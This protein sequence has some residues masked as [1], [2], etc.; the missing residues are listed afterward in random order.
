MET[1]E[2]VP[3]ESE[4]FDLVPADGAKKKALPQE[5]LRAFPTFSE[6]LIPSI[7]QFGKELFAPGQL[8]INTLPEITHLIKNIAGTSTPLPEWE[9]LQHERRIFQDPKEELFTNPHVKDVTPKLEV[10]LGPDG[11]PIV[12]GGSITSLIGSLGGNPQG[13]PSIYPYEAAIYNVIPRFI[14]YMRSP[15][16][17][18]GL[19]TG[20]AF[21]AA[22]KR[23]P[24][25]P[26]E[27]QITR[28][29]EAGVGGQKAIGSAFLPQTIAG[30]QEGVKHTVEEAKKE[31]YPASAGA[32]TDTLVNALFT[33]GIAKH[34][35]AGKDVGGVDKPTEPKKATPEP[36]VELVPVEKPVLSPDVTISER[37]DSLKQDM[38][39]KAI[40]KKHAERLGV[41]EK[42]LKEKAAAIKKTSGEEVPVERIKQE[43][44]QQLEAE[45]GLS[46]TP[47]QKLAT[48]ATQRLIPAIRE[49]VTPPKTALEIAQSREPVKKQKVSVG[50][51]TDISSDRPLNYPFPKEPIIPIKSVEIGEGGTEAK[52]AVEKVIA[53]P[54]MAGK[55]ENVLTTGGKSLIPV[56]TGD[57]TIIPEREFVKPPL[58]V[59]QP[60]VTGEIKTAT[61][62][63]ALPPEQGGTSLYSGLDISQLST[64]KLRELYM[65]LTPGARGDVRR[66]LQARGE[67][68]SD[69]GVRDFSNKAKIEA[70][71]PATQFNSGLPFTFK[72]LREL[73]DREIR[74]G[75][76][77][78]YSPDK[79][80]K[81]PAD[82]LRAGMK[83]SL[84]EG[85]LKALEEEGFF[86]EIPATGKVS[87]DEIASKVK[88][89]AAASLEKSVKVEVY[90]MEG[91]VSEA[92]K[93]YD[94]M[95]HEW[96]DT[97]KGS[98]YEK[99][100][101]GNLVVDQGHNPETQIAALKPENQSI[102]KRYYELRK[103]LKSEPADTSPRATS[104]YSHVS[105]LPTD[106]PMPD[107]T[108]TKSGKNVQRVDVVI[109][110]SKEY[111]G[112]QPPAE[113]G[114]EGVKWKADNLHENLPNTLG[115]AMIQYKT[116]AKYIGD[117][118][119]KPD[120][121]QAKIAGLMEGQ[122]RWGQEVRA[123][124]E[125]I[126]KEPEGAY[127]EQK[128]RNLAKYEH[129]LLADYNR[130]IL[131]SAIDQARKEGATHIFIS[132]A[133]SAL[134]TEHLDTQYEKASSKFSAESRAEKL[135]EQSGDNY[136]A[137]EHSYTDP[138]TGDKVEAWYVTKHE[139]GFDF[140]YDNNLPNIAEKLTGSKGEVVSI[141]EHKN[142][143]EEV[144]FHNDE[145]QRVMREEGMTREE[146]EGSLDANEVRGHRGAF[147][148]QRQNLI[149]RNKDNTGPKTDVSGRL[150]SLAP[151]AEAVARPEGGFSLHGKDQIQH[152]P[153]EG[154]FYSGLNLA[155]LLKRA[156]DILTKGEL[157][158]VG[159]Q[160]GKASDAIRRGTYTSEI[161]AEKAATIFSDS[162][163]ARNSEVRRLRGDF[164][165]EGYAILDQLTPDQQQR[166]YW[167]AID[168]DR[169]V[170]ARYTLD[171]VET[172]ALKA[173]QKFNEKPKDIA[174]E[175]GLSGKKSGT[176]MQ[177]ITA[178]TVTQTLRHNSANHPDV[179]KIGEEY[180]NWLENNPHDSVTDPVER[181][182]LFDAWVRAMKSPNSQH[183]DFA[184]LRRAEGI[185]L[186]DALI[187][188]NPYVAIQ[189]YGNRAANDLANTKHVKNNPAMLKMLSNMRDNDGRLFS[190][191]SAETQSQFADIPGGVEGVKQ[192]RPLMDVLYGKP[193]HDSPN[194]YAASRL[195]NSTVLGLSTAI[196]N[197]L[198]LPGVLAYTKVADV[199]QL[200]RD[201]ANWKKWKEYTKGAKEEGN[202]R[203]SVGDQI[204]P[205]NELFT[206]HSDNNFVKWA[207]ATSDFLEKWRGR[208][209]S[210]KI[211]ASFYYAIGESLAKSNLERASSNRHA[212]EY[213]KKFGAGLTPEQLSNPTAETVS[214]MAGNFAE[215]MIGT[216][217]ESELPSIMTRGPLAPLVSISKW[218]VERSNVI[219]K[220]VVHPLAK[221]A[222]SL[223]KEGDPAPFAKWLV[224]MGISSYAASQLINMLAFGKKT[225][226]PTFDEIAASDS[227][228]KLDE[229]MS[230]TLALARMAGSGGFM[231]DLVDTGNK[232]RRGRMTDYDAPI[233]FV[234]V[235]KLKE[236]V[237]LAADAWAAIQSGEDKFDVTT[238]Y[239]K[240]VML[241]NIQ[242]ARIANNAISKDEVERKNLN[243]DLR[244]FKR[245][246][247]SSKA[248]ASSKVPDYNPMLHTA[249]TKLK[250][251]DAPT[252]DNFNRVVDYLN[253]ISDWKKR[254]EA[255]SRLKRNPQ[256]FLPTEV[257]EFVKYQDFITKTQGEEAWDKLVQ[258]GFVRQEVE[259]EKGKIYKKFDSGEK[260]RR[261]F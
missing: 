84:P 82:A 139:K 245:L 162:L 88:K 244:V 17:M 201:I 4:V 207:S 105:A 79:E 159:G 80:G 241:R 83:R 16:G 107:W 234:P 64:E 77:F 211:E 249:E 118:A 90:G 133:K 210:N 109:P 40:E 165:A 146:A 132:D 229:Y 27:P 94:K 212:A 138:K 177:N 69:A 121:S 101:R 75:K 12:P 242:E 137:V 7:K 93:E 181:Q 117:S 100:A 259:K 194:T 233:S 147:K 86:R 85:E 68:A 182:G 256:H 61:E 171:A 186:P 163:K 34:L 50:E 128:S 70:Q 214:H 140:A 24:I 89:A 170:P 14:D 29:A 183:L 236:N 150:Y 78:G 168:V 248:A 187:E 155:P 213:V 56:E 164:T 42:E 198:S 19:M 112:N 48:A 58:S 203:R 246:D 225:D 106:E 197:F 206:S 47:E 54:F 41:I 10:K 221:F 33:H 99:V 2:L 195:V 1:F 153:T 151:H 95:T 156:K 179:I 224:G 25:G 5:E 126:K 97:L 103:Q 227:E 62:K 191:L 167:N 136:Q 52:S 45:L 113:I 190:E 235:Q 13:L 260:P 39:W 180:K 141:G 125:A 32:L 9:Q 173:L 119:G 15:Q 149:F 66:E 160:V 161:N 59:K 252:G 123:D 104:A 230:H 36:T 122:S 239:L 238:E 258:K 18:L 3:A 199:P 172:A 145:V 231:T 124:K 134:M 250:H 63:S 158:L 60:P 108:A 74:G 243:R 142:A 92:K 220:D 184:A 76:V 44:Q 110:Q 196:R 193:A 255:I 130:L 228:R 189:K 135:R 192:V 53:P 251:D 154:Y 204:F 148:Q 114:L 174:G 178:E 217:S 111:Q 87:V 176:Y 102:A 31:D 21:G 237:V 257:Q 98:E 166:V 71:S 65:R 219:H 116:G 46:T 115:W 208:K 215:R 202:I 152:S 205:E 55:S 72:S 28:S 127:K 185:G 169:G 216:Y 175:L 209:L 232:F 96:L 35:V 26:V 253:G 11:K 129:P 91:K 30:V 218:G 37:F 120:I 247:D 22:P 254:D 144:A 20:T 38:K 131:K 143:F 261:V 157:P 200:T 81:M 8:H 188:Q 43:A 223:G 49:E 222:F 67:I 23:I 240:Q 73:F 6:R 226:E 57:G 51:P